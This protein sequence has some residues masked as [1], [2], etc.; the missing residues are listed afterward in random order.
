GAG[1]E[2][3][4]RRPSGL[5]DGRAN[6]AC[7]VDSRFG[8]EPAIFGSVSAVDA[9]AGEGD[10]YVRPGGVPR[11]GAEGLPNPPDNPPRGLPG[12]AAQDDDL[13]AVR[14]EG[15]G[16]KRP[17]LPRAARNNNL[18]VSS[19]PTVFVVECPSHL[20]VKAIAA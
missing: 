5:G 19:L 16:Q 7:R 2:P 6:G 10:D 17:D 13:M 15:T 4:A 14:D 12:G 18:H 11:P 1:L 8:D 9:P 20:T 3:H